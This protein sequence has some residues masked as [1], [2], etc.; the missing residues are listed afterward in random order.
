MDNP[1]ETGEWQ[2][3]QWDDLEA[4]VR[5]RGIL[6]G[7]VILEYEVRTL[8]QHRGDWAFETL[9]E[10]GGGI[11]YTTDAEKA[12]KLIYGNIKWDGCG[13]HYFG[14]SGYIHSC[15][16]EFQMVRMGEIYKRLYAWVN[17]LHPEWML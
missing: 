9:S 1:Q 13:H 4:H 10:T 12:I 17:K 2:V 5:I 8:I 7:D 14:E 15:G 3:Q 11:D 16:G 6:G